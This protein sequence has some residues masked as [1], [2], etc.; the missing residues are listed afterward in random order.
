RQGADDPESV[1]R[2]MARIE[3]EAL[4][5]SELVEDLL[6]LARLDQGHPL[7]R[8]PVDLGALLA[9]AAD[10]ARVVEPDRPVTLV[11]PGTPVVVGGAPGRLRQVLDSL[12]ANVREHTGPATPVHLR[13]AGDDGRATVVV[14]DEGP[15]MT[16]AEASK[17]FERFWQAP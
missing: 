9:E 5:M 3:H 6:L 11:G 14:A 12:L 4:R 17:A 8:E 1:A 16:D 10:A 2:G 15:G 13:L 7:R